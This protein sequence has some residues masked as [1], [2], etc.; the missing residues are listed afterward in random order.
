[1]NTDQ[2]AALRKQLENLRELDKN[3]AKIIAEGLHIPLQDSLAELSL[4][5]NHPGDVGDAT[6]E[7]E[8]DLGFKLFY[9]DR[10]AMI[11][12]ALEAIQKGSYG[13][14]ASCGQ[15]ID[16][17][18]LKAVPYTNYCLS[19]K[20]EQEER[21][22]TLRPLEEDIL[23]PPF[24]GKVGGNDEIGFDGEDAWQQVARFGTSDSPSDLGG[25]AD[26]EDAYHDSEEKVG[27]V[28]EYENIPVY[29]SH[30]G[31]YSRDYGS[32]KE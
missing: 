10:L 6:F 24:G 25:V 17:E 8:K 5:D 28:E 18:R 14:C 29:K 26:Y 4:Y 11:E 9:E 30:D 31:S 7:R 27:A 3:Q 21:E 16:I 13:V 15:K 2:L 20:K 12:D 1:M 22:Q 32:Q 19:C 23:Y